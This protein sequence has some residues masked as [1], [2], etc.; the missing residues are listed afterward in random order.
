MGNR[1]LVSGVQLGMITALSQMEAKEEL[2]ILISEI[3]E[4]QHIDESESDL[5]ED[6][7]KIQNLLKEQT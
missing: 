6:V 1:Y 5:K 7:L 3:V 2:E 4:D